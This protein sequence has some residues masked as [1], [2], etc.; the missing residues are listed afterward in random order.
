MNARKIERAHM[1]KVGLRWM[2]LSATTA[3][4]LAGPAGFAQ[5]P[6][7]DAAPTTAP[8]TPAATTP[9]GGS[10][11]QPTTGPSTQITLNF[12]DASVD[13]VLEYL[14][15]TAGFVILKESPVSG[16]VTLLSRQPVTPEE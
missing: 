8:A 5:V 2:L 3:V 11:T 6:Q 4:S 9:V 16:R 12:R 7:T 10:T 13:A 14:S 15:S 1:T